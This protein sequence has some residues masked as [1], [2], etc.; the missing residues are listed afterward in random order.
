VRLAAAER[1]RLA[2]LALALVFGGASCARMTATVRRTD[3]T[4]LEA[5]IDSSDAST[6]RLRGPSGNIVS[7]DQYQ[8]ASIDHPGNVMAVFGG[9]SA[10][11]GLLLLTPLAVEHA[12]GTRDNGAGGFF[13]LLGIPY[14]I[15]GL[16]VFIANM[17][18]W[19]DSRSRAREF[20]S[21]RPPP[22]MIAPPVPGRPRFIPPVYP[23][24]VGPANDDED[25]ER[26]PP[27]G[28]HR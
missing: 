22:W 10:G 27:S 7:L 11:L 5:R 24:P 26:K 16:P 17:M 9:V 20:E 19:D 3:D 12:A 2:I 21:A 25:P 23:L 8:V 1:V 14:I 28:F 4:P 6:L 18:I 13:A 15:V